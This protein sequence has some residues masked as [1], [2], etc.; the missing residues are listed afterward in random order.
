MIHQIITIFETI[1]L[2]YLSIQVFY[3]LFFA[4]AGKFSNKKDFPKA[5]KLRKIRIFIPGYK[6]DA[7]IIAT[8]K[9]VPVD[10]NAP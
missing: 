6:E 2:A 10:I 4:L 1:I 7:V 3:L 9:D 5:Q 8:A